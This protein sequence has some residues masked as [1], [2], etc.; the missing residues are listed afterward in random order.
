MATER[1]EAPGIVVRPVSYGQTIERSRLSFKTQKRCAQHW[2]RF[3]K[4]CTENEL[5]ALPAEPLTVLRF[6]TTLEGRSA[7][8]SSRH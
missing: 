5:T 1:H 8:I 3:A 4:W 6:L 7:P 2:L